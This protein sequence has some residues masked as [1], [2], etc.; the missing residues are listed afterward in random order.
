[1]FLCFRNSGLLFKLSVLA[2]S[3]R[4]EIFRWKRSVLFWQLEAK[5]QTHS[6]FPLAVY[7]GEIVGN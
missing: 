7:D 3:H 6:E 2:G 1:M 5:G 4:A